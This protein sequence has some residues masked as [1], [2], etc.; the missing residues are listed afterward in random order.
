MVIRDIVM[1]ELERRGMAQ[2]ELA[3]RAGMLPHR[4]H[5]FLR[6][7]RDI[8]VETLERILDALELDIRRRRRGKGR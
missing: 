1:A 5:E 7:K 8:Y 6:G 3:R 4:V 2:A